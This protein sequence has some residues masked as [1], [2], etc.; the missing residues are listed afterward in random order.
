MKALKVEC[1]ASNKY[2]IFSGYKNFAFWFDSNCKKWLVMNSKTREE[3]QPFL[4]EIILNDFQLETWTA[5][6]FVGRIGD[7][8]YLVDADGNCF[9]AEDKPF[10]ICKNVFVQADC[11]YV[12]NNELQKIFPKDG[13][14]IEVYKTQNYNFAIFYNKKSTTCRYNL[15]TVK[16][17]KA[18]YD[19][20]FASWHSETVLNSKDYALQEV[21]E[22]CIRFVVNDEEKVGFLNENFEVFYH[23]PAKD[24]K[25]LENSLAGIYTCGDEPVYS[26]YLHSEVSTYRKYGNVEFVWTS[27]KSYVF[28]GPQPQEYSFIISAP[29]LIGDKIYYRAG[30]IIFTL[31][32]NG[33]VILS[34]DLELEE[35]YK[36]E[37]LEEIIAELVKKKS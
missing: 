7:K 1:I 32:M 17:E 26:S 12:V 28:A 36:I 27:D 24:V 34:K 23:L 15:I 18:C 30:S 37:L 4:D 8:Y 20:L 33:K 19:R 10:V 22:G 5:N 13:V 9:F 3:T 25:K 35:A 14:K 6:Y 31:N 16:G 2:F 21:G 29:K 11:K